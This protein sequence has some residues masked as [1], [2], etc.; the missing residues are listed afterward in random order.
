[1]RRRMSDR[2]EDRHEPSSNR[3]AEE[4]ATAQPEGEPRKAHG[5]ALL[6]G[7]GSRQGE[8]PRKQGSEERESNSDGSDSTVR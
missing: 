8:N 7:N 1:M 6:D 2:L 5:D 3:A 4:G